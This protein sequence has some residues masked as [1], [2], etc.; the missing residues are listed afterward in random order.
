MPR[1]SPI[2]RLAGA[3]PR[4]GG[5]RRPATRRRAPRL[6][7]LRTR[8]AAIAA[9][10]LGAIA[11]GAAGI[12]F[13][14]RMGVHEAIADGVRGIG[15]SALRASA[16]AGLGV[17]E[18]VVV[19]RRFTPAQ[20]IVAATGLR[21]GAPLLAFDPAAARA[22][23]E[24]MP[25]IRSASVERR[26]PGTVRIDLVERRPVALW[27]DQGRFSVLDEDGREIR[28]A[29]PGA[30]PQF[31]V[32]IGPDAPRHAGELL[33]LLSL[34]PDLAGRVSSASRVAGRRWDLAIADGG[35]RILLPETDPGGALARLADLHRRERLL[36]R[37]IAQ[38]DL[39]LAD[40][41]ALRPLATA[42][43]DAPAGPPQGGRPRG[44][45]RGN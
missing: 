25:W 45:I 21:E 15:G 1:M 6:A 34:E 5:A 18:I 14:H 26:F 7:W 10:C 36:D 30:F 24:R 23:L 22:E 8:R 37:S 19:G 29:D 43:A 2:A 17:R 3:G 31:V 33:R 38:I 42:S 4:L 39:R 44:A 16:Q 13:L 27:Q 12:G 32:V 9:A 40:R 35:P 28:G 20:D 41:M 11:L